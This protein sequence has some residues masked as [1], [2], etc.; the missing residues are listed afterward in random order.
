MSQP[1]LEQRQSYW[2]YNV[3]L[4]ALLLGVWLAV[5]FLLGGLL[6][7]WLDGHTLLGVPLGYWVAAQGSVLVFVLEAA[8]YARLMNARDLA[9]GIREE[10]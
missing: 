1:T 10:G 2:R 7:R 3:G 5:A 4:T 8:L 6:L 9:A